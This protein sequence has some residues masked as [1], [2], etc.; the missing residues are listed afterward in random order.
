MSAP[1]SVTPASA[2]VAPI[3]NKPKGFFTW[4]LLFQLL[5]KNK[6]RRWWSGRAGVTVESAANS[7]GL[8]R[9]VAGTTSGAGTPVL[10][11]SRT[12]AATGPATRYALFEFRRDRNRGRA[13]SPR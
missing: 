10:Q 2:Q 9:S 5:A 8:Q 6:R 7:E 12:S 11:H 4:Y 1:K 13:H 3:R